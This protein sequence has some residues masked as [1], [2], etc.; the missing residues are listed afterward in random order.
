MSAFFVDRAGAAHTSP[1]RETS[2]RSTL[3]SHTRGARPPPRRSRERA[4][5]SLIVIQIVPSRPHHISSSSII[6]RPHPEL[7]SGRRSSR[8][9]CSS[10]R[11]SSLPSIAAPTLH[12]DQPR[13]RQLSAPKSFSRQP[14]RSYCATAAWRVEAD[15]A[16][17]ETRESEWYRYQGE[18][19][20]N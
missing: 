4:A 19:V 9:C 17:R 13:G 8:R 7:A 20:C 18:L 15:A 1:P 3:T 2:H 10:L 6:H 12:R 11:S 14:R 16:Q 5:H